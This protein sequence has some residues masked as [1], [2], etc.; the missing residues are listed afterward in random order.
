MILNGSGTISSPH[1]AVSSFL[2]QSIFELVYLSTDQ[3][4]KSSLHFLDGRY[5][6]ASA[7]CLFNSSNCTIVRGHLPILW[8]APYLISGLTLPVPSL[9]GTAI[10]VSGSSVAVAG[11][12]GAQ[13]RVY[14]A[15]DFGQANNWLNL[16]PQPIAGSSP[17][18]VLTTSTLFVTTNSSSG[19][20]ATTFHLPTGLPVSPPYGGGG[21]GPSIQTPHVTAVTPFYGG[22]GTQ[23]TITGINF[24][25]G[26]IAYF[27]A[28]AATSTTYV[29]PTEVTAVTPSVTGNS[30][31]NITVAIGGVS[32]PTNPPFDWFTVS[33]TQ[34]TPQVLAVQPNSGLPGS[35]ANVTGYGYVSTMV[36]HFGSYGPAGFIF[37][38]ETTITA[39]VPIG[40]GYQRIVVTTGAGTSSGTPVS[41]FTI[42]A[43]QV[44]L[45]RAVSASPVLLAGSGSS[46]SPIEGILATTLATGN[47][48]FYNST[49]G[50]ASFTAYNTGGKTSLSN[51]SPVFSSIG[52]TRLFTGGGGPGATA[53][54]GFGRT[55]FGLFS[56]NLQNRTV[57]ETEGSSDGGHTWTGPYLSAP[58][59]GTVSS[60]YATISPAGYVYVTWLDNGAGPWQVDQAIYS[61]SGRGI[62]ATQVVPGSGGAS[63]FSASSPTVAID[64]LARPV[65]LWSTSNATSGGFTLWDTGAFPSAS[66]T[67]S[68]LWTAFN[69][70]VPTDYITTDFR[71]ATAPAHLAS[72][73]SSVAG[74]LG[75]MNLDVAR[76]KSCS[77]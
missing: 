27:G 67:L 8:G 56:T 51:G 23:V 21:A 16:T 73:R 77:S 28:T 12:A 33:T 52:S 3:N 2:N 72:F 45:P 53:T 59:I 64:N 75:Q 50:G 43:W 29:S 66:G 13:T 60:P 11:S 25:Y 7:S 61:E 41:G 68:D 69:T 57:V 31:V 17:S 44:T 26:A 74:S 19:V 62:S 32:S 24:L 30:L 9:A 76:R 35:L 20:V 46:T 58:L 70:T 14:I 5:D 65:Y 22:V 54:V 71:G 15:G 4:G 48:T 47:V 10:A 39:T 40:N 63:G 55:I 1:L 36:S 42:Q 34:P 37:S 6:P 38:N 18:L 49:N